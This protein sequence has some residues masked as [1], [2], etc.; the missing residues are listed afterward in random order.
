MLTALVDE[1]PDDQEALLA[2]LALL[3]GCGYKLA[4]SNT[5]LPEH[6][7]IIAVVPF[8]NRTN[9]P[10]IEQRVTLTE[11]WPFTVVGHFDRA[12]DVGHFEGRIGLIRYF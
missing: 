7:K 11:K 2:T 6:I 4:G 8:D 10:E 9:R 3:T 1:H 12:Y 5:F